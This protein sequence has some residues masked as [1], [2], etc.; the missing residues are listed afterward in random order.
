MG[1]NWEFMQRFFTLNIILSD[2]N[3]LLFGPIFNI[4]SPL[5]SAE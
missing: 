1:D 5:C 4:F 2:H 3:F